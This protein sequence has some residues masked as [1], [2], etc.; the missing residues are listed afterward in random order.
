[1]I[2]TTPPEQRMDQPRA[3]VNSS[4]NAMG[5]GSG[6]QK[7]S[8]RLRLKQAAKTSGVRCHGVTE[9][10]TV[11]IKHAKCLNTGRRYGL[12]EAGFR[13]ILQSLKAERH[14]ETNSLKNTENRNPSL[15]AVWGNGNV[16][17]AVQC[18]LRAACVGLG[19]F[20]RAVSLSAWEGASL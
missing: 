2:A 10:L 1:M 3:M 13:G 18:C 9:C 12:T 20:L 17:K 14:T 7:L 4:C 6:F 16:P 19:S 5:G 11:K 8:G 15:L